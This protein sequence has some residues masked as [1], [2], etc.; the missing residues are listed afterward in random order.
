MRLNLSKFLHVAAAGGLV[1]AVSIF[2]GLQNDPEAALAREAASIQGTFVSEVVVNNPS[3]TDAS[4]TLT[5]VKSDGTQAMA[6]PVSLTVKAGSS[7]KTYVPNVAGLADGRYSVV[8]DSDQNVSAIVNLV[9]SSPATSTSYNGI[10]SS[11]TGSSFSIPSV[12]RNYFGFS[13]SIVIQNAG[14]AVANVTI[15]Y[16][17]QSGATVT[18]ETKTIA[19][20]ASV[21]VDQTATAGLS[22]NFVGSAVVTSDQ[23]VAAIFLISAAGQLSS[24]RG[25]KSG[26]PVLYMPVIYN[27]YFNFNTNVL[28][29]NVGTSATTVKIEYFNAANGSKIGEET[30]SAIQPGSSFT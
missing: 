8:V 24:A 13:S 18:S 7:A 26:A 15:T 12:Y 21:T 25:F 20:N 16:K 6:A 14:T 23:P 29:Q 4:V 19:T 2:S 9:S 30:S 3:A 10:A 11:D 1:F 27:Q 17:S 28:V 22:D 5:F